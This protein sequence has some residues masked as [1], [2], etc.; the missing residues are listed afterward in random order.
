M[1]PELR[2][3]TEWKNFG[4]KQFV[5]KRYRAAIKAYSTGL[6]LC[7]REDLDLLVNRAAA[8]INLEY[9]GKAL[10]D[11]N[12]VLDS[13]PNHQKAIF[14]KAKALL[15]LSKCEDAVKLLEKEI[16]NCKKPSKEFQDLLERAQTMRQQQVT[17]EYDVT[18]H[19]YQHFSKID[20]WAEYY[21]P[22]E[23][24]TIKGKG[25]GLIATQNMKEGQLVFNARAFAIEFH[26]PNK[27]ESDEED[28]FEESIVKHPEVTCHHDAGAC[29]LVQK[30][31][32]KIREMPQLG[33][34]LYQLYAGIKSKKAFNSTKTI[35]N[36]LQDQN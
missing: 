8:Y 26:D 35:M 25:R 28:L 15:G 10:E 2:T 3:T 13:K 23:V 1:E 5:L 17:G 29:R 24:Q 22:V 30:V 21:G 31:Y 19:F 20:N 34:D 14:R 7:D 12:L 36:F 18:E 32:D 27:S 9:F 33:K 11:V 6:S 16:S 4:N